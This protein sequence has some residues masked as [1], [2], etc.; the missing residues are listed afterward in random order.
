MTYCKRYG[1]IV[2]TVVMV[3]VLMIGGCQANSRSADSRSAPRTSVAPTSPVL[4]ADQEPSVVVAAGA[5]LWEQNC[6]RCH[7]P[8]T[9][10]SLSD[11]Q[12]KVVMHHMRV[13]ANLTTEEHEGILQFLQAAN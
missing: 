8:R 2:L 7:N 11:T 10:A 6:I 3:V 4:A 9:P 12:W 13:R 5:R 1:T